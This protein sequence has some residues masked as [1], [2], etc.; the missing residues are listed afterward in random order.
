MTMPLYGGHDAPPRPRFPQLARYLL[1]PIPL[2][3][4]QPILHFA[5]RHVAISRP[6]LFVRLGPHLNKRFL[7][8]AV[9][10]PFVLLLV[11]NPANYSLRPIAAISNRLT[12]PGYPAHFW[13]CS[14]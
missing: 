11:A 8:D 13:T 14:T 10:L 6:E 3:V 7:I 5:A 1:A 2:A 4:L 9:E 12:T